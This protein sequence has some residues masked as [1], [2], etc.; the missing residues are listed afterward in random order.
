MGIAKKI[1][2]EMAAHN[3][4]N[5]KRDEPSF[6]FYYAKCVKSAFVAGI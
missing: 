3:S 5:K 1:F 2:E 4:K 6:Y